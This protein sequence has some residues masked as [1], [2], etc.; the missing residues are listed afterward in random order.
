MTHPLTAYPAGRHFN[1]TLIAD[2]A[3]VADALIFATGAFPVLH[4]TKDALTK[5]AITFRAQRAVVDRF[6]LGNFPVAPFPNLF[7]RRK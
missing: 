5:K 4:R 6:R 1:T 2:N 7:W 3:F